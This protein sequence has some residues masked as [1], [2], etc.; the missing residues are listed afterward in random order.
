MLRLLGWTWRLKILGSGNLSELERSARP[1]LGVFLHGRILPAAFAFRARG[2]GVMV[3]RH[4]DGELI[5]QVAEGLGFRTFRGSTTRGGIAALSA[6]LRERA[7]AVALTPDGPRGPE[8]VLQAGAFLLAGAAGRWTIPFGAG[9]W[10]RW[11]ARSWDRFVVPKPF[12]AVRVVLGEAIPPPSGR[13]PAAQAAY[14]ARLRAA[15]AQAELA[16]WEAAGAPDPLAELPAPLK[17]E[18]PDR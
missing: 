8:G 14:M 13:G 4:G 15:L 6:M 5:A 2:I 3:S 10:P 7:E 16:A 18:L 1:V 12:A 9:A 11:R 17:A